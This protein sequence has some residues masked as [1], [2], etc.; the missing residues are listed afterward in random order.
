[1]YTEAEWN[2]TSRQELRDLLKDIVLGEVRLANSSHKEILDTC[3]EA[4]IED[5]CPKEEWEDF[6]NFAATEIENSA[7]FHLSEQNTWPL[8]TDSDRLDRVEAELRNKG[9][10]LWQVS[11]CCDTC[12]GS[13]LPDRID[14]VDQRYPGFRKNLRGYAFYIDQNMPEKLSESTNITVYLAY[15]W[16]TQE[17]SEISQE[18]YKKNALAI[19]Q[20]ICECL[21]KH[22]FN[23]E[24]AGD[25]SK[26]ID[27]SLNWQRRKQ[28]I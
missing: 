16:F 12:S 15:G 7:K 13:E 1:M 23:P 26:K 24:W 22:G 17:D 8:V 11:P 6:A 14:E 9:I 20:E 2:D 10:L 4:Y 28:I 25:F 27:V 18:T 3:R 5:E 19:A 21:R